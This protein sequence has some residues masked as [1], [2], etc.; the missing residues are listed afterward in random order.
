MKLHLYSTVQRRTA[1]F[2]LQHEVN[3]QTKESGEE[4]AEVTHDAWRK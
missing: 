1:E 4:A 3:L 2:K